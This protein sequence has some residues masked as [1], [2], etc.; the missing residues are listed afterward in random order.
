ML[1]ADGARRLRRTLDEQGVPSASIE[2]YLSVLGTPAALEAAIAWYRAAAGHLGRME[3]GPVA[4]PT[5]YVWGD[6]DAT[7]GAEAARWTAD[8]VTGSYRF[9]V[10]PGVGHFATDQAPERV[11]SL[12]L[13]HLSAHRELV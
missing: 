6:A 9:E 7:V 2:E 5:L 13:D 8:D 4:V 10:L 1:L 12:I 11:T 3:A